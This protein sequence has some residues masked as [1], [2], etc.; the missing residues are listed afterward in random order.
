MLCAI[1][2]ICTIANN[3]DR[4][5]NIVE[6]RMVLSNRNSTVNTKLKPTNITLRLKY[7]IESGWLNVIII[8]MRLIMIKIA[9]N[10]F[11]NVHYLFYIKNWKF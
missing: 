5:L 9:N 8:A 2:A 4:M 11:L 3:N 10:I 1:R 6:R 7:A